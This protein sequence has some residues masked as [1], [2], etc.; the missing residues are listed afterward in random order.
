MAGM[1]EAL[2]NAAHIIQ[3]AL[4]PIFLLTAVASLLNV[5]ST[6]L[7]RI[8]DRIH[9]MRREGDHNPAQLRR[10]RVRSRLLELAVTLAAAAGALTCC[11]AITLFFG[12][13]RDSG[14][15]AYLFIFFGGALL[16]AVA[17]L[18]CFVSEIFLTGRTIRQSASQA[19]HQPG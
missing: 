1:N 19:E 10:L 6:R 18:A 3:L 7:A 8:S 15:A 2:S 14:R 4:T 16:C 9:T 5:F 13:L 17:G 11:S 12:V